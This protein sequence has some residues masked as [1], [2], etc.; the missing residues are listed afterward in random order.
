MRVR[1]VF[2]PM[3]DGVRLAADLFVP[4]DWD[5][6]AGELPGG[7]RRPV[8][9]EYLPYRKDE[10][11][12]RDWDLYTHVVDRDRGYVGARVDIRGT[13]RSEGVLPDREYSDREWADGEVVIEWLARR[14]W[15][16]GAVAM[17]GISWGG[18]N[19][20][21]MAMREPPP[22]ALKAIA[23]VD[24]SDMLFKDDVHLI[25]GI[26][27]VDEYVI[28]I[29][30]LNAMTAPP[31]FPIDD[32]ALAA[33]FDRPPWFLTWLRHQRD[34]AFWQRGSLAPRYER[35]RL[36]ALL[37]GGWYDGYRD[38]VPRMLERCPGPVK[39]ILGPWNHAWPHDATPGPEMEWRDE[40]V[41]WF[42]RWLRGDDNGV[43][44]EPA[45]AVFVRDAHPPRTDLAEIPGG[46]R[47][48]DGWPP[49]GVEAKGLSLRA[50]G[51]LG[52][53]AGDGGSH[54]LAHDDGSAGVEAGGWWGELRPDQ[55]PFDERCLTYDSPPLD[56]PV[57]I[58]GFPRVELRARLKGAGDARFVARLCD[59]AP[60]GTSTLVTGA[61]MNGS[62]R[63]SA[64]EPT[65]L[66]EG[67]ADLAFDLHVTSWRFPTGH[68][69]RLAIS[70]TCW[71]MLWPSP[72]RFVMELAVGTGGSRVVLP[73]ISGTE[74]APRRP[75]FGPAAPT[76]RA[77]GVHSGDFL[78]PIDWTSR[79]EGTR[80]ISS[81][82]G[83]S[84]TEYPWGTERVLERLVFEVD[85]ERP[86]D[87]SV[88]G[89]ARTDVELP[90][91]TLTWQGELHL[92]TAEGTGF[93]YRYRREL[94][95]NGRVVRAREW[96]EEIPRDFQ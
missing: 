34:G 52:E 68:R 93:R 66:P 63:A 7:E 18:F 11:I 57:E 31:E 36:P 72:E 51:S 67:D 26:M 82:E 12:D 71:P 39:A 37:I 73:V 64:A 58:V 24:A 45:L 60:D 25:D 80:A 35:M 77:P 86:A 92:S 13:G 16:T 90:G 4:D 83:A 48:E 38:S 91:R 33:R 55:T 84:S 59:V 43:D 78:V 81:W 47:L 6:D 28:M 2:I 96:K 76:A 65:P 46:W 89:V 79:R 17:W 50:D 23:A 94:T 69:I 22:P 42:D 10:G 75:A 88:R 30:L 70:N 9:L 41:R 14:P 1:E 21:Q 40:A 5:D 32:A 85:T 61:A 3:P 95:E 15:C 87:A 62:Q 29:D 8:I 20:I 44:R 74:R 56:E 19:S 54:R 27:H 49:S 53:E